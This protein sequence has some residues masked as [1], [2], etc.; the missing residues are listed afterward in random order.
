MRLKRLTIIHELSS[1]ILFVVAIAVPPLVVTRHWSFRL[2][3]DYDMLLSALRF[4]EE[5]FRDLQRFLFW[6]PYIGTGIPNLGDL[7]SVVWSPY[8][9]VPVWLFG[10]AGGVKF[11]ILF[12]ICVSGLSMWLLLKSLRVSPVIRIWGSWLSM[13]SGVV[14]ASLAAGHV[15]KLFSYGLVPVFLAV[16]IKKTLSF[17]H[18][19]IAAFLV[20]VMMLATDFYVPSFLLLFY[21]V[22]RMY[23]AMQ[24]KREWRRVL[25]SIF[26]FYG[27][28]FLMIAPKL[29]FIVRDVAPRFHRYFTSYPFAGSIHAIVFPLLYVMPLQ[30]S[31]YDRPF[32][33]RLLGFQYNWYE[34]Y[35]FIS[36]LPF[37]ALG[38][39]KSI[40]K[41]DEVKLFII[42]IAVGMLYGAL[43]FP[44]SPF[45]WLFRMVPALHMFRVPSRIATP[46][47]PIV[48][49]LCAL[50]LDVWHR[51]NKSRLSRFA[52]Y[53]VFGG[54]VL[55]SSFITQASIIRAFEKP[56]VTE[57]SV[58]KELRKLDRSQY[59]VVNA[60]CCM[61][62]FL[63]KERIPILNYYHVWRT[64]DTP[65]FLDAENHFRHDTLRM[66]RPTYIIAYANDSFEQ[67]GFRRLFTK[68]TITV[69]KT[70]DPT[71]VPQL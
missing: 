8:Y 2:D 32:F 41:R 16:S 35:A 23:Y 50:C 6:N 45:Y 56:R 48:I 33:Q 30:V 1:I 15:A 7:G 63:V 5:L 28:V 53:F 42:L 38:H 11:M 40:V 29:F 19:L 27:W 61:Q 52:L 51:K 70:D 47:T 66:V 22:V 55:W 9:I 54:S 68:G 39:M 3:T 12:A 24:Y 31:F 34:Y 26:M 13:A 10:A 18:V 14:A 64:D 4:L 46:L 36:P 37:I 17:F 67:Y 21:F 43:K 69:W 60:V 57:E 65:N 62:T 25:S 20:T 71:I 44:Y 58:A 49:A 59:F